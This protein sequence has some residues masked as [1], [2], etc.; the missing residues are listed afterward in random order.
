MT[1]WPRWPITLTVLGTAP[2]VARLWRSS[3]PMN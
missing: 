3:T 2:G 1:A